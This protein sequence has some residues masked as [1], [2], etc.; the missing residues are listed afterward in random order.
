MVG[1]HATAGVGWLRRRWSGAV[2]SFSAPTRP[3]QHRA[4]ASGTAVAAAAPDVAGSRAG[5]WRD[6][7]ST[8]PGRA[9]QRVRDGSL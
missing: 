3:L 4:A 1:I 2:T 9:H 5:S 8:D 7:A 6:P